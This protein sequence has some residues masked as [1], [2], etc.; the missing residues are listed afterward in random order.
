MYILN[1]KMIDRIPL[2][3]TSIE[4]EVFPLMAKDSII[5]VFT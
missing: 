5:I 3:P 1:T 4:R 2:K